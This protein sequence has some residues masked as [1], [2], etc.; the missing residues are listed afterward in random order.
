[1]VWPDCDFLH[2]EWSRDHTTS[3]WVRVP[4]AEV[5]AV[6]A[7]ASNPD[8]LAAAIV[9]AAE[10]GVVHLLVS[11]DLDSIVAMPGYYPES[12]QWNGSSPF[13]PIDGWHIDDLAELAAGPPAG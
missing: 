6:L 9:E 3:Y 12:G 8:A 7:N 11:E 4:P 2:G 13:Q 10:D 5:E 1:M